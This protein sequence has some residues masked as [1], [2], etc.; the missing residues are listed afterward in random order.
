M[1]TSLMEAYDIPL[2]QRESEPLYEGSETSLVSTI[3][4]SMK[5]KVVNGLSNTCFT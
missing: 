3:L 5:L 2:L 4:L 1:A